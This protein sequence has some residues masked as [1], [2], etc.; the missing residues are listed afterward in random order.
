MNQLVKKISLLLGSFFITGISFSQANANC[1]TLEPIC[2]S[3]GV[4]F[5]AL[6]GVT[7]ASTTNPG[8]NYACFGSSPNPTWYYM[9][10][11]QSGNLDFTLFANFDIDFI[12][13]G[14]FADLTAAQNGCNS[15]G[16]GGVG[17]NVIDCSY[18]STN[19]ETPSIPNAQVGEIYVLLI[20]NY[21]GVV[22]NV[23]F[24][25]VNSGQAGAGAL[26]CN[27]IIPDPCVSNPGTYT[28]WKDP[29]GA[30]PNALTQ[31]PVYLCSGDAFSLISNNDYILPNDTIPQPQGDGIYSAQ[32]MWLVY[33]ALP[34]SA[35]P[36]ADPGFTGFAI[37]SEDLMD[38]NNGTSIVIQ[39][40]GCG[41]YYFV[42]VAGDDGVGG[43][44]N[45]SNGV[46]DNGSIHWDKDGNGCYLL[47]DAIEVTYACP[48]TTSASKDCNFPTTI[49]GMDIQITGGSGSYTVVNLGAGNLQSTNVANGGTA[50]INDL[51]NNAGWSIQIT[52][53]EGCVATANG[54]FSAPTFQNITLTPAPDCPAAGTGSVSVTVNG[55]SGA[56]APYS[57]EMASDPPTA[58]TTDSYTDVAGTIVPI[59]ITDSDGCVNDSTVTIPSAGHYINVTITNLEGEQCWGDGNGT[60]TIS[61]A[62]VPSGSSTITSIVWTD[63]NNTDYPGSNTN[64]SQN[65][66][67]PG[68]WVVC[69][70][71]NLGCEVCIPVDIPAPQLLDIYLDNENDPVC[72]GFNDGSIDVGITG[73]TAPLTLSWSHNTSLTGDVANQLTAGVYTCWVTDANGCKDSIIVT[74]NNPDSLHGTFIVK[75]VDCFGEST[76][77]IF[78]TSVS[79]NVGN[80]SYYWNTSGQVPTPADTVNTLNNCPSGT[81]VLTLQDENGCTNEY[82]FFIDQSPEL[83]FAQLGTEPAYCRLYSY[84]NGNGQVYASATGGTPDYT[85]QWMDMTTGNVSS[86]TTWGGRN[87]GLYQITMTDALGCTLVQTI[88]LDSVN[89]VAA[90]TPTSADFTSPL[91]GTSPVHVEFTNQSQYFANPLNPAADT[92]FYWNLDTSNTGWFVTHDYYTPI[93]TTYTGEYIYDVCLVAI[94]KNGCTDTACAQIIVHAQPLMNTPNVFTP[95]S[96]GA[97]DV[98][99]FR[100]LSQGVETFSAVIVDR[101]GKTVFEFND[102]NDSWDGKTKGG[103]DC[104]DGVYFYT[105]DVG[106]TN[107]TS[108]QGQG[109]ITLIREK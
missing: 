58:G 40:L 87:P 51:Y 35:D 49:N 30:D 32:L 61:V 63:P 42:P 52:D 106:F 27:I 77:G 83:K 69:V 56:G 25:Q 53:A 46:N 98:F 8:N 100:F 84:Q 103:I 38:I 2:D 11:G 16:N 86:N 48:M 99:T 108:E 55:T 57:I 71:D 94:N 20:T 75:D 39:N 72:Y 62:P 59:L 36:L 26:D 18:S 44:N 29:A 80:V 5:T 68:A 107:G 60:A 34:S 65:G 109:N 67:M 90:F 45:V 76:G 23:T 33:D 21:A 37:P 54:V 1:N 9:Q 95:G 89:P 14:P 81:Y 17:A 10:V 19:N 64:T 96:D 91:E 41:T 92:T 104:T 105:Y 12:I 78:V 22:Q 15:Y 28:V 82:Q 101:W 102:I 93:D 24:T 97:N 79:G 31:G 13:Y 70:T 73:G 7:P 50:N 88:Q 74:V 3:A 85:Y 6:S 66:M 47:G 43:N 4:N